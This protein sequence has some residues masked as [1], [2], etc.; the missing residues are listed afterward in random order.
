MRIH[1]RNM[2]FFLAL[3]SIDNGMHAGRGW[4]AW[5]GVSEAGV[6]VCYAKRHVKY[7]SHFCFFMSFMTYSGWA[8]F[9]RWNGHGHKRNACHMYVLRMWI[10]CSMHGVDICT[11]RWI[12][13]VLYVYR[14]NELLPYVVM[15]EKWQ[16]R[17]GYIFH[18]FICCFRYFL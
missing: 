18:N 17:C 3:F 5:F 14:S 13:L 2:F 6:A 15:N 8:R 12:W 10:R 9:T 11:T 1:G 4:P 7:A 16:K